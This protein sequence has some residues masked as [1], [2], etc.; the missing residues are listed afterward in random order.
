M[1]LKQVRHVVT[2]QYY[3]VMLQIGNPELAKE[4][5]ARIGWW[6]LQPVDGSDLI[7]VSPTEL[8]TEYEASR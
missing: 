7:C 3:H 1:G 2:H 6:F 8:V 4:A 5:N